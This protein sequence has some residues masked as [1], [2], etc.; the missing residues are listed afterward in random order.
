MK[1]METMGEELKTL[2]SVINDMEKHLTDMSQHP[3]YGK[4]AFLKLAEIQ[5]SMLD[6]EDDVEKKNFSSEV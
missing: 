3:T 2:D 4:Y 1:A 5:E 6:H